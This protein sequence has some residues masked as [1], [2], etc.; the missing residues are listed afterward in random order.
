MLCC[1]NS[2]CATKHVSPKESRP[3]KTSPRRPNSGRG[4]LFCSLLQGQHL[5]GVALCSRISGAA[6]C[7][8]MMRCDSV[9]HGMAHST[10]EVACLD[11]P[12]ASATWGA[13][14]PWE[15]PRARFCSMKLPEY[16]VWPC[17][18][19]MK[20]LVS[21]LIRCRILF[22]WGVVVSQVIVDWHNIM[23]GVFLVKQVSMFS[24]AT[25]T[26]LPRMSTQISTSSTLAR[27]SRSTAKIC[28]YTDTPII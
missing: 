1:D 24:F 17:W 12:R 21:C 27:Y 25:S 2:W 16:V 20:A 10:H 11:F 13:R 23:S 8:D 22:I 26:C 3:G 14:S 6:S 18:Y 5:Y 28:T 7:Y 15:I 19:S 9:S 4:M